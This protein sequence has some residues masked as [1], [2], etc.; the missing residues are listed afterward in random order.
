M[1]F[2]FDNELEHSPADHVAEQWTLV[3]ADVSKFLDNAAFEEIFGFVT[4]AFVSTG[5]S[6]D[7]PTSPFGFDLQRVSHQSAVHKLSLQMHR[8]P[9][10]DQISN[11]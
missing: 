9:P 6:A 4:A 3:Y 5:H 10:D 1:K 11:H 8:Y 7:W 2:V